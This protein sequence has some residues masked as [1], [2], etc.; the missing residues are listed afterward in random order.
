MN[1][2]LVAF[3]Y[4]EILKSQ[5][6]NRLDDAQ[7]RSCLLFALARPTH[8]ASIIPLIYKSSRIDI[9]GRNDKI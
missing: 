3:I 7:N 8:A 1:S 2:R 5:N 6:V 9:D 4:N